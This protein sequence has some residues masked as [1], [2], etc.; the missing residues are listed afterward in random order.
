MKKGTL[1]I[2]CFLS[3]QTFAQWKSYYPEG[4]K[5]KTSKK[6]KTQNNEK[7]D[8]KFKFDTHFYNALSLKSLEKNPKPTRK[9]NNNKRVS[10]GFSII[11]F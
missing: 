2:L 10:L 3:V 7:G 8:T 6:E 5:R 4:T 9:T 11:F 1:I